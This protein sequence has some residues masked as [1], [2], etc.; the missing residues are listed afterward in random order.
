MIKM[1]EPNN[2]NT[3]QNNNQNTNPPSGNEP[4]S[5]APTIDYDKL[6]SIISGKQSATEDTVL[7][8]YFKQ[9]GLSADEMQQAIAT[10]KE[11]KKQ[12]T[13]DFNKMQS[14]LDSANNAR[15]IAEVN[16]VATLEV[17]KQGVDVSSVPY[18]LKLADFS[19]ATTDGKIDN[20][21]LSEAVKKVLD[22]VP[23][24][25][26]QSNDGAGVQKIGGDG[27]DNKNP[28]EDTLRGIF[29]I[30]TKK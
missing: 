8:S 3:N 2:Q 23:A 4:S 14:D 21:K 10:F 1:A 28:D 13:P 25:K 6:A 27:G 7:K 5:N 30:R 17:I 20:D 11:Q 26:K 29:G 16:Q 19:G 9:Q 24:L 18:V 15:L 22:E 12:N